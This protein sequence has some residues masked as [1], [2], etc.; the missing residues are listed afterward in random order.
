MA[1][2]RLLKKNIRFICGDIASECI[3]AEDT[4]EGLDL[5]KMDDVICRVAILQD[6]A[7]KKVSAR[8]AQKPKEFANVAEYRKAKY[9]FAKSVE[10]E[11]NQFVGD[12]LEEIVKQM[13]ALVPKAQKDA[14][15]KALANE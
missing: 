15:V 8:F 6:A 3:F 12:A 13:N 1:N 9:A 14:I 10:K 11:I 4:F 7:I 5:D 2:K